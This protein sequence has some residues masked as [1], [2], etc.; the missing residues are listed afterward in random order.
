MYEA[1]IL[2][3]GI[4]V[5]YTGFRCS[6]CRWSIC[7]WLRKVAVITNETDRKCGTSSPPPQKV[8]CLLVSGGSGACSTLPFEENIFV[9]SPATRCRILPG[10]GRGE[11]AANTSTGRSMLRLL[12]R[13]DLHRSQ[14]RLCQ[15]RPCLHE[16]RPRQ[17]MQKLRGSTKKQCLLSR[18]AMGQCHRLELPPTKDGHEHID[19][20]G[21]RPS[22]RLISHRWGCDHLAF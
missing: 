1:G 13:F 19:S 14:L 21:L 10:S 3:A 11:T 4:R 7:I 12:V 16:L 8:H 9:G 2:H 15:S 20:P 22:T 5:F 18:P 17:E 6:I